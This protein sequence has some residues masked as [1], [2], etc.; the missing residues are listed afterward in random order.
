VGMA[1]PRRHS[2]LGRPHDAKN[3]AVFDVLYSAVGVDRSVAE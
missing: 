3:G 1:V 2:E